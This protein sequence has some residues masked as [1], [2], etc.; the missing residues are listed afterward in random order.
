MK[1]FCLTI[2][3]LHNLFFSVYLRVHCINHKEFYKNKI[4]QMVRL[5]WLILSC[6]LSGVSV[7]KLMKHLGHFQYIAPQNGLIKKNYYFQIW[8]SKIGYFVFFKKIENSIKYG[9]AYCSHT[10]QPTEKKFYS[11]LTSIQIAKKLCQITFYTKQKILDV[12]GK[13]DILDF[14][15][16]S[17][18]W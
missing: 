11:K 18:V 15:H 6:F 9:S 10:I 1:L 8:I 16:V 14:G 4:V 12:L 17:K 7:K 5:Q 3:V 2:L 13:I